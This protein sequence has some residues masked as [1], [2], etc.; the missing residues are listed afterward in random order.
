MLQ[1]T[2][3]LS[4]SLSLLSFLSLSCGISSALAQGTAFTYQGRLVYAGNSANGNFD[5][6]FQLWDSATNGN[7]LSAVVTNL[8]LP[9]TNGLFAVQLDFGSSF[10]GQARYL[11]IGTRTSGDTNPP[12]ILSPRQ[13]LTPSPYAITAAGLASSVPDAQLS[14]NVALLNGNPAFLGGVTASTFTGSGS[15]L[16]ALTASNLTGTV[17]NSALPADVALT[18]APAQTFAGSNVFAGGVA[19][20]SGG[21]NYYMVPQ[22]AIILWSGSVSNIPAGWALCN[23]NNGTPN[24]MDKFVVAAGNTYSVG[25]VGGATTHTH[26]V[27]GLSVPGLSI[28]GLSVPGLSVPGLGGGSLAF[29]RNISIIGG[30]STSGGSYYLDLTQANSGSGNMEPLSWGGT[31]GTGT[32]GTGTTGT[33]TTGTGTTG[34]GTSGSASSLPPYYALCYI[35]KL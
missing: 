1:L 19:A 5:L 11:E 21:V 18:D 14:T 34:A 4:R 29:S 12:A 6:T 30:G 22:G 16:T 28:P 27:P 35:M 3:L 17:P 26:S 2:R 31:T 7:A 9:I 8:A 10:P 20:V 24:L 13:L 23:G 25:A 33:G 32:T 15:G